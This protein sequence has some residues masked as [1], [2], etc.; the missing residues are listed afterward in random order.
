MLSCSCASSSIIFGIIYGS[1]FGLEYFKHYAIWHD[2][3]EGD[4]MGLMYGAIAVGIIMISLGLISNVVNRFL[5]GDIIGG[6][7]DKFGVAGVL[8]YW[9]VLCHDHLPEIL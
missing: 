9:G 3:L 7:F 1:V 2:P 5:Q 4:P 6:F 8:F